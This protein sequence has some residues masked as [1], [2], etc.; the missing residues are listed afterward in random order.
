M[1]TL[2]TDKDANTKVCSGYSLLLLVAQADWRHLAVFLGALVCSILLLGW[3]VAFQPSIVCFTRFLLPDRG[4]P[5]VAVF[6]RTL[7]PSRLAPHRHHSLY[8][9][10]CDRH[11][12]HQN[13]PRL[14][15]RCIVKSGQGTTDRLNDT[16]SFLKPTGP[17]DHSTCIW[18]PG[19]LPLPPPQ[20]Y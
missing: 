2:L 7:C 1:P 6:S 13:C 3:K 10:L 11:V 9:L 16:D 19:A 17:C 12:F 18:Q 14:Q 4:S 15:V 20:A 5:Q 8:S